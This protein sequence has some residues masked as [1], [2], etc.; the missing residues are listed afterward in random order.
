MLRRTQQTGKRGRHTGEMVQVKNSHKIALLVTLPALV[1]S[2]GIALGFALKST[3][4]RAVGLMPEIVC[5]AD[6]SL[7]IVDEIVVRASRTGRIIGA[8]AHLSGI[9]K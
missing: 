4:R 2:L 3:A 9:D 8:V 6:H 7:M 1:L 5:T